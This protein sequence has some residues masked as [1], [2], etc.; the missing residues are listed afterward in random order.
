[1]VSVASSRCQPRRPTPACSSSTTARPERSLLAQLAAAHRRARLRAGRQERQRGVR[2]APSTSAFG[3][4]G[5]RPRR[6]A[7]SPRTSVSEAPAGLTAC[8]A[9]PIRRASRRPSGRSL[10]NPNGSIRHAGSSS[11]FA[12]FV[13]GPRRMDRATCRRRTSQRGCPVTAALQLIRHAPSSTV[14]L[15]DEEYRM[16]YAA[17]DYCLRVF[18]DGG[19]CIFEPTVCAL[20]HGACS[21]AS[22]TS[23]IER[24]AQ[25]ARRLRDKCAGMSFPALTRRSYDRLPKTLFI[26]CP[27]ASSPTT[28]ASCPPSCSASTGSAS[29]ASRR[30]PTIPRR[31]RPRTSARRRRS[32]T[33]SSSCSSRPAAVA[34]DSARAA[35]R[36]VRVLYEIDDYMQGARKIVARLAGDALDREVVRDA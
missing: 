33:T 9:G 19:E 13:L 21:A 34:E 15:Y 10:L 8:C 20:H 25:S 5:D 23:K 7:W 26:G 24:A 4:R 1:M 14:G 22:S 11:R 31:A 6:R 12:A 28:A 32:T 30:T 2:R 29:S 36:G 27:T 3:A 18:A 17:L 16:A 35:G